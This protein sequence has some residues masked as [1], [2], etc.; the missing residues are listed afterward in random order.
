[1][2]DTSSDTVSSDSD[3]SSS[4]IEDSGEI[5]TL[6]RSNTAQDSSELRSESPL[7]GLFSFHRKSYSTNSSPI[8]KDVHYLGGPS[9]TEADNKSDTSLDGHDTIRDTTMRDQFETGAKGDSHNRSGLNY[10]TLT[11]DPFKEVKKNTKES[12]LLGSSYSSDDS[13]DNNTVKSVR[14]SEMDSNSQLVR[15]VQP[16]PTDASKGVDKRK[17][18]HYRQK[19]SGI[20]N[21]TR[22]TGPAVKLVRDVPSSEYSETPESTVDAVQSPNSHLSTLQS[23]YQTIPDQLNSPIEK[24]AENSGGDNKDS[25]IVRKKSCLKNKPIITPLSSATENSD[26]SK[27]N[28]NNSSLKTP[29]FENENAQLLYEQNNVLTMRMSKPKEVGFEGDLNH[30]T[31]RNKDDNDDT[32]SLAKRFDKLS[33]ESNRNTGNAHSA[34]SKPFSLKL[35]DDN[36][37]IDLSNEPSFDNNVDIL[38]Q[39]ERPEVLNPFSNEIPRFSRARSDQLDLFEKLD[40]PNGLKTANNPNKSFIKD[41]IYQNLEAIG[42]SL[43]FFCDE[44]PEFN[45]NSSLD[46]NLDFGELNTVVSKLKALTM[47]CGSKFDSVRVQSI[48]YQKQISDL[49]TQALQSETKYNSAQNHLNEISTRNQSLQ[50]QNLELKLQVENQQSSLIKERNINM[51]YENDLNRKKSELSKT[52]SKLNDKTNMI[53]NLTGVI[54]SYNLPIIKVLDANDTNGIYEAIKL[55]L[56]YNDMMG[57]SLNDEENN[58]STLQTKHGE[59][60]RQLNDLKS[61]YNAS[62]RENKILK[63]ENSTIKISI[64]L[65]QVDIENLR[66]EKTS[67]LEELKSLKQ[68]NDDLE[69]QLEVNQREQISELKKENMRYEAQLNDLNSVLREQLD[70]VEDANKEIE[71]QYKSLQESENKYK[72]LEEKLNKALTQESLLRTTLNVTQDN[73]ENYK[74]KYNDLMKSATSLEKNKNKSLKQKAEEIKQLKDKTLENENVINNLAVELKETRAKLSDK[75][76]ETL[77]LEKKTENSRLIGGELLKSKMLLQEINRLLIKLASNTLYNFEGIID[78]ESISAVKHALDENYYIVG[79]S[80]LNETNSNKEELE[81]QKFE[82]ISNFIQESIELICNENKSLNRKYGEVSSKLNNSDSFF[83]LQHALQIQT[84]R[85]KQAE[86]KLL[87]LENSWKSNEL[88]TPQGSGGGAYFQQQLQQ[89]QNP[90][91]SSTR[92]VNTHTPVLSY[93]QQQQLPNN[94]NSMRFKTH[95]SNSTLRLTKKQKFDVNKV[96]K[97]AELDSYHG[98]RS[99]QY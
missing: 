82:S 49:R 43:S 59:L 81:I 78:N 62:K 95:N 86:S 96:L 8:K 19:A 33:I 36:Q 76:K 68:K 16:C 91:V 32:N 31:D 64:E 5:Q 94:S 75:S 37:N 6:R 7:K 63:N 21:R 84:D 92:R 53:G 27:L 18:T 40:Y 17:K 20:L 54:N 87:Q 85:L 71:N 11:F 73:L 44:T 42:K 39:S 50:N 57:K 46:N 2:E 98:S 29:V 15:N 22:N 12:S 10:A 93:Q 90:A 67:L 60:L 48:K 3:S 28:S 24:Q 88:Q 56:S 58:N 52:Q 61:D 1:M 4:F 77:L 23:I 13:M 34:L 35:F 51:K 14:F 79:A 97:S 41:E 89:T 55:L 9:A 65:K 66:E 25:Q 30:N 74:D 83:A 70:A 72:E 45:I 69:L 26:F 38:D 47:S 99:D 80:D